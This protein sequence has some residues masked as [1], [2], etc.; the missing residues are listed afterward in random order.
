MERFIIYERSLCQSYRNAV[1][2]GAHYCSL[3]T[4]EDA[5]EECISTMECFELNTFYVDTEAGRLCDP[6]AE[7][8]Y[9][10]DELGL[11]EGDL[12]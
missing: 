5:S 12:K 7:R 10:L 4:E 8:S 9:S 3:A 6:V 1:L 2:R 11:S